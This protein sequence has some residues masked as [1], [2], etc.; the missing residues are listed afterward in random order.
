MDIKQLT[1]KDLMTL[2]R[3]YGTNSILWRRRF[4]GL[5]PEVWSRRLYKGQG[6]ASIYE[7]AARLGG[8]SKSIVDEVLNLHEK[9]SDRPVLQKMIGEQGWG[10]MK[11]VERASRKQTGVDWVANASQMSQR[12]L[13]VYQK[14]LIKTAD[15]NQVEKID[16]SKPMAT[17]QKATFSI[18]LDMETEKQLRVF[19]AKLEKETN[20]ALDWNQVIKKLLQNKERGRVRVT[21]TKQLPE[22]DRR[23]I[24]SHVRNQLYEKYK[25]VC[26][27]PGC[28]FPSEILHHTRRFA[29]KPNHDPKYIAPLCKEHERLAH[30]GLV[31]N[32]E[33]PPE[34]WKISVKNVNYGLKKFIDDRVNEYRMKSL[35]LMPP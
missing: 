32:E 35:N 20:Q 23:Y 33:L 11:I 13:Q 16:S 31:K 15:V 17:S 29:L 10:K 30:L 25:G 14:E 26:A 34:Q 8:V 24:P 4:V 27:Y 1:D 12:T 18:K 6:F 19:K 2:C 5:L 9:L 7:F 21:K 3:E 22:K 28:K